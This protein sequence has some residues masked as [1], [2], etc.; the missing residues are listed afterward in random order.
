MEKWSD[1]GHIL[2]AEATDV[3]EGLDM[4]CV[5]MRHIHNGLG[6]WKDGTDISWDG[7]NHERLKLERGDIRYTLLDMT[8][9]EMPFP[10]SNGD[11][12]KAVLNLKDRQ[13]LELGIQ[14]QQ[15]W[16]CI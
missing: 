11:D 1:L 12:E 9:F 13:G 4:G 2:K 3:A 6:S 7:E 5:R 15:H 10:Q 16:E 8:E 14:S